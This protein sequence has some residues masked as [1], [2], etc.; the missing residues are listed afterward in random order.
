MELKRCGFMLQTGMSGTNGPVGT[1]SIRYDRMSL[2]TDT[3]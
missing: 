1:Y 2:D 3:I